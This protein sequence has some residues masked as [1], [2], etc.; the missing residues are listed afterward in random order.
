[1]KRLELWRWRYFDPVRKRHVTTRFVLS[2]ADAAVQYPDGA[3]KVEGSLEVRNV[4]ETDEERA[5]A[6]TGAFSASPLR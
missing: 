1:M 6:S 4:P 3:T 5:A 2:D